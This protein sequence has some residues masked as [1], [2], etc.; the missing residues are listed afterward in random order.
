MLLGKFFR[1]ERIAKRGGNF[2]SGITPVSMYPSSELPKLNPFHP[3][4]CE[5]RYLVP[6]L[7]S[8]VFK[9]FIALHYFL[10]LDPRTVLGS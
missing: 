8:G 4:R 1:Q 5:Y 2:V 6:R 10:P 9:L 3:V 7:A